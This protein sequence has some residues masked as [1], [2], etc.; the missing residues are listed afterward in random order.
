M[1]A[2]AGRRLPQPVALWADRL[3]RPP[4]HRPT[5]RQPRRSNG[6]GRRGAARHLF[7]LPRCKGGSVGALVHWSLDRGGAGRRQS[8][9]LGRDHWARARAPSPRPFHP[10]S[11]TRPD[12]AAAARCHFCHTPRMRRWP[13]ASPQRGGRSVARSAAPA[14]RK[15][16]VVIGGG[17]AAR[18]RRWKGP[19]PDGG[20][21]SASLR[22]RRGRCE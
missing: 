22:G 11:G 20:T 17:C 12:R 18:E 13:S 2:L 21:L 7:I 9:S 5:M 14:S 15:H 10:H 3:L 1:P 16:P 4:L 6:S 8:K 19:K